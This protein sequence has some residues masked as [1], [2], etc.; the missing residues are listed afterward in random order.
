[1]GFGTAV[2]VPTAATINNYDNGK[3]RIKTIPEWCTIEC[4]KIVEENC[5]RIQNVLKN[6]ITG[7]NISFLYMRS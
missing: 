3:V 6:A 1:M 2:G 4:E 7:E 5:T